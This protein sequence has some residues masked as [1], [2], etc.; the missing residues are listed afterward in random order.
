MLTT[1][2]LLL[3]CMSFHGCKAQ[4]SSSNLLQWLFASNQGDTVEDST[5]LEES[6]PA[7]RL[8]GPLR[9]AVWKGIIP[10]D[11]PPPSSLVL[12]KTQPRRLDTFNWDITPVP[13]Y[14]TISL[15][16]DSDDGEGSQDMDFFYYYS[17]TV[18]DDRY[19]NFTLYQADCESPGDLNAL[20]FSAEV[21]EADVQYSVTG[22][23]DTALITSSV[24]FSD[25]SVAKAR[26]DFCMRI[27]Y[28]YVLD[29]VP[30]SVTFHETV[31]TINVDLTAGF[32]LTSLSIVRQGADQVQADIGC[33]VEAY[34][35]VSFYWNGDTNLCKIR[36]YICHALSHKHTHVLFARTT[37]TWRSPLLLTRK[38]IF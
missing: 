19:L 33:E 17:G 4:Q 18:S 21:N 15:F 11:A 1:S 26:I 22:T 36:L 14:P 7:V 23:V 35:C 34:F 20:P 25:V 27:D 2:T 13:G 38:A 31:V 16:E 6:S 8:N 28:Y 30:E 32:R 29:G 5:A 24:H 3:L 10:D 37:I 9:G 12:Q